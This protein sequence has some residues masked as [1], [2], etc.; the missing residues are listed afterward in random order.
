M[1]HAATNDEVGLQV[2]Q[3]MDEFD[4]QAG[5][6][7]RIGG[8]FHAIASR[9]AEVQL[10]LYAHKRR[11]RGLLAMGAGGRHAREL[12]FYLCRERHCFSTSSNESHSACG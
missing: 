9:A 6:R 1:Q 3:T 4:D 7:R 12:V 5:N 11:Q 2:V 8:D 10:A